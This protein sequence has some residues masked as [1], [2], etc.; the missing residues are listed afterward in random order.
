M[1]IQFQ[2][3]VHKQAYDKVL[4]FMREIFGEMCWVKED[5]PVIGISAGSSYVQVIVMGRGDA[6]ATVLVRSWVVTGVE[7][8]LDLYKFLLQANFKALCGGFS[9]DDAGDIA[10]DHTLMGAN[11]D[12]NELKTSVMV[13]R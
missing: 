9:L 13:V 6:E 8:R 2:T 10:F 12:K 1:P 5:A 11:I 7:P 3:P 4:G